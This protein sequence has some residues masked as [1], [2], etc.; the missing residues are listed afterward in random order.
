MPLFGMSKLVPEEEPQAFGGPE[1]LVAPV[2]VPN[3]PPEI[4]WRGK[5]EHGWPFLI[6]VLGQIDTLETLERAT[7]MLHL[8]TCADALG[9]VVPVDTEEA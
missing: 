4:V 3:D 7:P 1:P 8:S 9:R 2:E 6:N 5:C